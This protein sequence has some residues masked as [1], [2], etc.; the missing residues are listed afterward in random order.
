[1]CRVGLISLSI[2]PENSPFFFSIL[3]AA[4]DVKKILQVCRI[5]FASIAFL[6]ESIFSS[7]SFCLDWITFPLSLFRLKKN[8]ASHCLCMHI[9]RQLYYGCLFH[10]K[11]PT[12]F[13]FSAHVI[14]HHI[15]IFV[16][17][18][19]TLQH[20]WRPFDFFVCTTVIHLPIWRHNTKS[21][22]ICTKVS[23]TMLFSLLVSSPE[24]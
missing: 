2:S 7:L 10:L 16:S 3:L 5:L 8:K 6:F 19:D 15:L 1:M 18:G 21:F 4:G 17:A 13:F 12:S 20:W 9:D 23:S 14:Q 11:S 22:P 24:E